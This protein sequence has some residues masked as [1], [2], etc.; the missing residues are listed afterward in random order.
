MKKLPQYPKAAIVPSVFLPLLSA[1]P[2]SRRAAL[3]L[4]S[5]HKLKDLNNFLEYARKSHPFYDMQLL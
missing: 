3:Q 2:F 4:P 5:L 1:V